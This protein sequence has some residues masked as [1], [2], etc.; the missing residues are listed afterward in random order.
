MPPRGGWRLVFPTNHNFKL[1]KVDGTYADTEYAPTQMKV[2]RGAGIGNTEDVLNYEGIPVNYASVLLD[3]N[4]SSGKLDMRIY[5]Q[6]Q[7]QWESV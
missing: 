7:G 6:D 3:E 2:I 4:P 5:N 1:K